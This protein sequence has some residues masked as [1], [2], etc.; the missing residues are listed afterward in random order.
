MDL[1]DQWY[2]VRVKTDA[3]SFAGRLGEAGCTVK[4]QDG[5]LL[6]RLPSGRSEQMLWELAASAGEQIR[7]LRPQKSTLG[8]VFEGHR[9]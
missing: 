3:R 4:F 8:S 2:E 9:T 6:V 1:H 5:G 7:H